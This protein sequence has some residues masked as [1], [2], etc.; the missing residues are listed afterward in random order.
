MP[1]SLAPSRPRSLEIGGCRRHLKPTL[2]DGQGNW[3]LS[4]EDC[5][6][7]QAHLAGAQ[8][9]STWRAGAHTPDKPDRGEH[10]HTI[11]GGRNPAHHK[12]NNLFGW[13][14]ARSGA[15]GGTAGASSARYLRTVRQSQPHSRPISTNVAPAA[16]KA[17]KRRMFI[18]DSVSRI[19]SRAPFGLSAWRWTAEG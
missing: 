3:V 4:M 17:R 5:S 1:A 14:P 7:I 2:D 13:V 18:Q 8:R 11:Q 6:S 10:R 19:M 9:R 12:I 15:A 16:C